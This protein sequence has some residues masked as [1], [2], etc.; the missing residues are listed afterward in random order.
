MNTTVNKEITVSSKD[1][2]AVRLK[3]LRKM[4]QLS[5]KDFCSKYKLSQGTLQNWETARFGGLTEKGAKIMTK[6]LLSEGIICSFEWLMFQAGTAP[7]LI[8]QLQQKQ[9]S[10]NRTSNH[11][12]IDELNYFYSQHP[13]SFHTVI[14]DDSM[15]P[16]YKKGFTVCGEKYD[17]AVWYKVTNQ[18][19]IVK[20]SNREAL[21]RHVRPISNDTKTL[22]LIALNPY[23]NCELK[24]VIT[25]QIDFIAPIIWSRYNWH[26]TDEQ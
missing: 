16:I 15:E 13:S 2:R 22:E 17:Q 9:A 24:H 5:R 25:D 7:R 20:L 11:T 14:S 19:C 21:V 26:P 1:A 4:T 8:N 18:N 10:S 23:S 3:K 6:C 12:I